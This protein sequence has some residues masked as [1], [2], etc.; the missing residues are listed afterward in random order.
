M[1]FRR[2]ISSAALGIALLSLNLAGP[3]MAQIP[4]SPVIG[5]NP[6]EGIDF[7]ICTLA[8]ECAGH[9][10]DVFNDVNDPSSILEVTS[11]TIANGPAFT[12]LV[13]PTPPFSIPGDG[14]FVTFTIQFCPPDSLPQSGAFLVTAGNATNSPLAAPLSGSWNT[15]PISD[16]GGPYAGTVGQPIRFDAEG[17]SDP[18]GEI[19]RYDWDF[20]D[21]STGRD[22]VTFHH[23]DAPGT[24]AVALTVTDNC[25]ARSTCETTATITG[26]NI[27]PICDA[28]GPYAGP[29]N[30]PIQFDG[31]GS[32]DPDGAIVLYGWTFGDGAQGSGPTPTHTYTTAGL[33]T[34]VLHV[35]DD[36][37]AVTTCSTRAEIGATPVEPWTWG[38]IK[39]RYRD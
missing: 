32:S 4:L 18:G 29:E 35:V 11:V 15:A 7:G 13:G 8:G 21:G 5:F 22:P 37:G 34:V 36:L 9:T 20:G 23:Y 30:V 3:A 1:R 38:R 10:I 27:P 19:T 6:A 25:G 24:Y 28:G 33:Y 31:T 26:P 17:S 12:I 39:S 2:T 16:T 14:S